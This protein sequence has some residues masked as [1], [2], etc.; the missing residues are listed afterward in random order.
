MLRT[1]KI[2]IVTH[3][4]PICETVEGERLEIFPISGQLAPG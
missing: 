2:V 4:A 1:P 3:Y